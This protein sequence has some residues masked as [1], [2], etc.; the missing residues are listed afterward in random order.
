LKNNYICAIMYKYKSEYFSAKE[1]IHP[2]VIN[3]IGEHNAYLRLDSEC[4]EDLDVIRLEW[5]IRFPNDAGININ[6]GAADS[7]GLR[8]PNDPDG[9][10]YSVHKMGKAFD[11]VPV[12]VQIETFQKFVKD[13]MLDGRLRAF[14]TIENF[15]FTKSWC[16]I[17]KMNHN[18]RCLT[19]NP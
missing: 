15:Q 2:Q 14:N 3:A 1:L 11:L 10:F 9:G 6:I 18:E 5:S 12:N 4:L 8:P 7:R 17:A 13:L 19:I 16:H